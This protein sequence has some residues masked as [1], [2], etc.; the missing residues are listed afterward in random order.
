MTRAFVDVINW[1]HE[2]SALFVPELY[3]NEVYSFHEA[4]RLLPA[5]CI[6]G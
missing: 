5:T 3:D 4:I 2:E 1:H 6:I